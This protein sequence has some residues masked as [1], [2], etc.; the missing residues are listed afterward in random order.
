M[1]RH[2]LSGNG[3]SNPISQPPA[4]PLDPSAILPS[5]CDMVRFCNGGLL[6]VP[7]AVDCGKGE[8]GDACGDAVLYCITTRPMEKKRVLCPEIDNLTSKQ[9]PVMRAVFW[10]PWREASRQRRMTCPLHDVAQS[11]QNDAANRRRQG[12]KAEL[13]A[14]SCGTKKQSKIKQNRQDAMTSSRHCSVGEIGRH[15]PRVLKNEKE[16]SMKDGT[17]VEVAEQRSRGPR[18]RPTDSISGLYPKDRPWR[19]LVT[20]TV[21]LQLLQQQ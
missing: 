9:P 13:R 10:S 15:I 19:V 8:I 17:V 18:P 11:S 2:T 16:S 3:T 20:V 6:L 1:A 21:H 7:W 4:R 14:R 12:A 5:P